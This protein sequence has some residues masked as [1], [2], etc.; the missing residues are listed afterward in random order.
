[1]RPKQYIHNLLHDNSI[2]G[3]ARRIQLI[4]VVTIVAAV[5]ICTRIL[6]VV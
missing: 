2:N 6:L 5:C 1:M 4:F 3:M